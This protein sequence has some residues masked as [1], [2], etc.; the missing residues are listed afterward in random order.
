MKSLKPEELISGKIY[1]KEGSPECT[2]KYI[3]THV[4]TRTLHRS[5]VFSY[6]SG[7][8][9]YMDNTDG[10]IRFAIY[11]STRFVEVYAFKYGK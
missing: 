11:N 5:A 8:H 3:H 4:N 7:E 2:L 10:T 9:I 6:N 1:Y